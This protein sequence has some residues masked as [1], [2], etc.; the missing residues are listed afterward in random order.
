[1]ED[2]ATTDPSEV[3][4]FSSNNMAEETQSKELGKVDA[5]DYFRLTAFHKKAEQID[6]IAEH[7]WENVSNNDFLLHSDYG[8]VIAGETYDPDTKQFGVLLAERT[9]DGQN[10]SIFNNELNQNQRGW[11]LDAI[12][13]TAPRLS[14]E[15]RHAYMREVIQTIPD[16]KKLQDYEVAKRLA[17]VALK[18][19]PDTDGEPTTRDI[20]IAWANIAP[21]PEQEEEINSFLTLARQKMPADRFDTRLQALVDETRW[22]DDPFG[23]NYASLFTTFQGWVM[24]DRNMERQYDLLQREPLAEYTVNDKVTRPISTEEELKQRLAELPVEEMPD[25]RQ[26]PRSRPMAKMVR[27]DSVVGGSGISDWTVSTSEGRGLFK[28]FEF[29]VKLQKGEAS[30]AGRNEP[31][32]AI[33][34]KGRYYIEGDGRHRIAALKA[35]GVAEAPMLVTH[36]KS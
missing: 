5:R 26:L 7:R 15:Q 12:Y 1:M 6:P 19:I 13:S 21:T 27:L 33:E 20:Q 24:D 3:Q 10:S 8:D 18:V 23:K 17:E 14:D 34:V 9:S 11:L 29:T 2:G 35:L 28:I 25:T 36:I 22:I 30:V 4:S 16:L 31:V 32:E